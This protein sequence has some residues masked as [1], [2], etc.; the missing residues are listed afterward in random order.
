MNEESRSAN[1]DVALSSQGGVGQ[2]SARIE[3][4]QASVKIA[5]AK[6]EER[7][8]WE[9]LGYQKIA[10]GKVATL[11]VAGGQGTRLGC[12]DPKGTVDIGLLSHR[13]LFQIQA[14]RLIKLQQLVTDRLGKP[15]TLHSAYLIHFMYSLFY[16]YLLLMMY[17]VIR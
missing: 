10:E 11:V 13:S 15:C 8:R 4:L 5:E 1:A 3:P 14:E 6:P 12:P 16:F 7:A 2:N 9:E 17:M